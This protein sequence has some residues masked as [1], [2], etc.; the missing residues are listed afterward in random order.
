MAEPQKRRMFQMPQGENI[1]LRDVVIAW[2]PALLVV[3]LGGMT[4][5]VS[6]MLSGLVI[7]LAEAFGTVYVSDT[8]GRLVPYAIFVLIM[9]FRPQGLFSVAQARRV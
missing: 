4:N 8:L 1:S 5:F 3:V 9:L 2:W 6:I 7:G